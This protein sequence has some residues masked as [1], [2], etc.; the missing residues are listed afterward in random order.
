MVTLKFSPDLKPYML[1]LKEKFT[2]YQLAN[3]LS[4]KSKYSP[5]IYEIL[6]CNEFKKQGYTEIEL[7]EL[8]RLLKAEN[9]YPLYG[10][11]KRRIL[12]QAQK[13][14][15]KLSDIS[16]EF[17]EIKTGRT[18]TALKFYIK[19]NITAQKE[20]SATKL[21]AEPTAPKKKISEDEAF[22]VKRVLELMTEKN[23]TKGEALD[24]LESSKGDFTVIQKVYNHF[25]NKQSPN[26][27]GLMISM[28][29]PGVFQQPKV[30]APKNTFNDYEQRHYDYNELE[31][32]LT[33]EKEINLRE[34]TTE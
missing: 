33:G 18:I 21:D 6:K 5:R 22:G 9:I 7:V 19:A 28:V 1:L 25:K 27:I 29:R 12:I 13:E 15:N 32:G 23:I 17:E 4:M 10:D 16:F 31:K 2:Q 26:F 20:I 14:L 24:I 8:R 11:F 30:N 3:I 34:I